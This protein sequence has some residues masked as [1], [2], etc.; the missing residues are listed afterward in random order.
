MSWRHYLPPV[1]PVK[2]VKWLAAAHFTTVAI[3][4]VQQCQGPSMAP[5]LDPSQSA[6]LFVSPLPYWSWTSWTPRWKGPK[7][8]DLVFATKP[9]L[10][11]VLVCKRVVGL[12]GDLIEV[13]PRRDDP[14]SRWMDKVIIETDGTDVLG[15][16]TPRRRGQEQ[17]IKVPKGHVWLVGDNL[18]NSTDSRD[19]GPV[20]LALVKG[21]VLAR[22]WPNPTWF[23]DPFKHI[24]GPPLP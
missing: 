11:D 1:Q 14:A 20:P 10:P 16:T 7:R 18:K 24:S 3:A 12:E 13:E 21:Q 4:H 17:W 2:L 9:T 6:W 8:G 22:V 15:G 19:Y 23:R 5:T